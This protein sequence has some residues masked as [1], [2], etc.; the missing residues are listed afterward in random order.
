MKANRIYLADV[1]DFLSK[2][3]DDSV[4]L[5]IADPPYNMHKADWDTFKSESEYFDFTFKWI[6]MLLPKCKSSASI[7]LFNNAYN[8]AIILNYLRKR[9]VVF[10]NWITWYKKDGFSAT[11]KKYV[12]AQETIL[13]YTKS[14]EYIFNSDLVRVPYESVERMAHAAKKGILKDGKRWFPNEKGKL[15]NDVWEITSQRHKTKLNGKIQNPPHPTIKPDE[16][17]VRMIL[18]SSNENDLVLDLFSGSGTTSR[19]AKQL[20]RQ[21][22]GCE[23]NKLYSQINKGDIQYDRL[24]DFKKY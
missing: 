10:R 11:R 8:S 6:D 22:I 5:V 15:C 3:E 20:G 12:N 23:I 19:V 21:F 9:E 13:F 14:N 24:S 18:A 4:D 7:Y 1:F 16:M 17:I 2:L